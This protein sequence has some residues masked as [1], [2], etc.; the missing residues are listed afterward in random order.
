ML[1]CWVAGY[2]LFLMFEG[3]FV[4]ITKSYVTTNVSAKAAAKIKQINPNQLNN[5][6]NE[7]QQETEI[8]EEKKVL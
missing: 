5:K 1:L 7:K 4:S 6:Q 2:F 8:R 3:P